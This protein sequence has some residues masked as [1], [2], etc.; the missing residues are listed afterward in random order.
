LWRKLRDTRY[1]LPGIV[2]RIL[3]APRPAA[4]IGTCDRLHRRGMAATLGYFQDD[5]AQPE[6]VAAANFEAVALARL[7]SGDVYLS[8]KAPAL[9][10]D[11]GLIREVT[12]AA[13]GAGMSVMFDA[14]APSQADRT[15]DLAEGLQ[16][17]FPGTGCV[18]PARWSRSAADAARFRDLPARIRLVKGEWADPEADPADLSA[19]FL[20]LVAQLAGRAAPVSVATHE[21]ALAERALCAL[22]A[23][24]TPCELE[25]LRGMPRR[26]TTAIARRIGAPVRIYLPFGPGWWPY[27]IDKAL[28]RPRLV[29]EMLKDIRYL[30][31]PRVD[32]TRGRQIG[33]SSTAA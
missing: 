25:Q 32:G 21:P 29:V 22:L 15:L 16:A 1:A 18:L 6:A 10:F 4:V 8:V 26:R 2:G 3:P 14:H 20:R 9:Q 11:A 28:A 33:N 23:A 30:T 5:A 24:R 12:A 31:R 17:D 19:S 7:R 13:A 27:A